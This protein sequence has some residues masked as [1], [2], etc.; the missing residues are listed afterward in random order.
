[1]VLARLIDLAGIQPDDVVLDVA[2][3]TGY[4]A[5][6]LSRLAGVVVGIEDDEALVEMASATLADL[7]IDN[8]AV[9]ERSLT[10]GCPKQGPFNVIVIAA[11]VEE[12]PKALLEQLADGGRLVTVLKKEGIGRGSVITRKGSKFET[13]SVFDANVPDLAVFKKPARFKF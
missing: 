4:T 5:A 12:V 8:A 1:M 9:I 11:G 10:E 6:I 3:A 2:S 7:K 13:K